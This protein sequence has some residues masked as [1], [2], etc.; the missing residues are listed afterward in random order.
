MNLTLTVDAWIDENLMFAQQFSAT[1]IIAETVPRETGARWDPP[2]LLALRNRVEKAGLTL[3]GLDRLPFSL[4][5]TV[6]G[7]EGRDAEI[8]DVCRF[9]E[10][11]GDAGVPLLGYTWMRSETGLAS[12]TP[13]GRG[14][15]FVASSAGSAH[16]KTSHNDPPWDRLAYFLE[17]VL[18][19]AEK[20]HV[21]M[22]YLPTDVFAD[23]PPEHPRMDG[24]AEWKRLMQTVPSSCHGLE[25]RSS[26]V[27]ATGADTI[28]EARLLSAMGKIF[29]ITA[30]NITMGSST[31]SEA[32]IDEGIVNLPETLTACRTAGFDGP[33]RPGRQPGMTP[34][35][36]QGHKAMAMATGYLRA[37]LQGL[38]AIP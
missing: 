16:G 37:L 18:P 4:D 8:R 31:L 33:I 17:R 12:R 23:L 25:F 30:D 24:V 34:D 13:T 3:L 14:Q 20:T 36:E 22:M 7:S 21:R 38:E 26:A 5:R 11:C 15:A 29:L 2:M 19:I 27:A 10:V 35:T 9:V 6:A 28:D 32:F 1:H